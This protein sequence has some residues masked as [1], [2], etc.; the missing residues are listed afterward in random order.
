MQ[1]RA[2][3]CFKILLETYWRTIVIYFVHRLLCFMNTPTYQVNH[4]SQYGDWKYQI[5]AFLT[6]LATRHRH[7]TSTLAIRRTISEFSQKLVISKKKRL[8]AELRLVSAADIADGYIQDS[9]AAVGA[10][11]A[12]SRISRASGGVRCIAGMSANLQRTNYW[13][14]FDLFPWLQLVT[15][16]FILSLINKN[17]FWSKERNKK[18]FLCRH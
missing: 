14:D 8:Y 13:S 2:K 17:N 5:F 15:L 10:L 11:M 4:V 7:I 16:W 18:C 3:S 6:F 1:S 9:G 12:A